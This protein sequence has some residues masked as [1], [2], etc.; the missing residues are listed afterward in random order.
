MSYIYTFTA[1]LVLGFV[2][3]ALTY[4]NNARKLTDKEM[5]GKRLLDAL[6]GR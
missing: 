1:A 6:K 4:R 5:E 3:G 2:A